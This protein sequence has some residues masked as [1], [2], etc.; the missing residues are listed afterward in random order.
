MRSRYLQMIAHGLVLIG[1]M[2]ALI[3]VA[4]WVKVDPLD[5]RAQAQVGQPRGAGEGG[6][7]DAAKQRQQQNEQLEALNKRMADIEKGLRE[8]SFSI[9]I[10]E[11]KGSG[12]PGAKE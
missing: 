2:L 10:L 11:P 5:S 4:L 12:K 8:G 6:I 1:I 9:Q 7:P 3:A